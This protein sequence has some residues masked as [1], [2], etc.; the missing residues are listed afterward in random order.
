MPW[1]KERIKNLLDTN[2]LAVERAV[3][4]IYDRQTQDEKRDSDTKH[5]NERGFRS[6]HASTMSF[7][8]R[9][10]LKGWKQSG[11]NRTYLNSVKLAKARAWM[12]QYHRQLCEVANAREARINAEEDEREHRK[13]SFAGADEPIPGTYAFTARLLAQCGIMTG[14][15][16]DQW[17]DEMKDRV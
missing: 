15:E 2:D 14:D 7:Y 6:N 5:D 3:V 17:K 1:T 4:A 9:I 8:A 11:K 16:A 10:I 12:M 13:N